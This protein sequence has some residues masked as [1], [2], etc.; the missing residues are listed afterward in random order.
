MKYQELIDDYYKRFVVRTDAYYLQTPEGKYNARYEVITP[1]HL[2][3]HL[4]GEITIAFPAVDKKGLCKWICYDDDNCLPESESGVLELIEELL[5]SAGYSCVREGR[6]Q[7]VDKFK[8]GH[9][10]IMLK[11]PIEAKLARAWTKWVLK[12]IGL[13]ER[14]TKLDIFPRQA[15]P[16]L[17]L[18]HI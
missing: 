11:E 4:A 18:I 10:W 5:C 14:V 7:I 12:Q 2:A 6:R 17:S 15:E 9:L 16:G 8:Q 1:D 13:P 3:K